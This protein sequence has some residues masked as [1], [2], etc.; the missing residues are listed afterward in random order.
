MTREIRCREA[1]YDCDFMIQSEDESQLIRFV[2]EHASET[3]DTEMSSEDIRG[4]W[5]TVQAP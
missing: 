3:H 1:G 4:A 5:K 2:Q